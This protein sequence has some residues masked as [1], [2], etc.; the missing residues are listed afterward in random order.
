MLQNATLTQ[1]GGLIMS[2]TFGG[3]IAAGVALG[4]FDD[5]DYNR[6]SKPSRTL[7]LVGV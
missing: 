5:L 6:R 2:P 3:G 1:D 4:G 7:G